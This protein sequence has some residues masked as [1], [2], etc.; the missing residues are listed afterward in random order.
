MLLLESTRNRKLQKNKWRGPARCVA[1]ECDDN[2]KQ[3]VLWL[4]HGTSL[5]RC[6]PQQ[7]RPAVEDIGKDVSI[8]PEAALKDLK[9][10]RARS[11]TQFKDA[12]EDEM[13]G[14]EPSEG[15]DPMVPQGAGALAFQQSRDGGQ[16]QEQGVSMEQDPDRGDGR[17]RCRGRH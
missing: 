16:D 17:T 11:T 9:D 5:L 10:L 13:A 6:S 2:G 15:E 14:H 4:C 1:E 12:L 3:L 7:V 8:D